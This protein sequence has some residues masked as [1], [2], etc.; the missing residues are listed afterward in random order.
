MAEIFVGG[1][2]GPIFGQVAG[3][4][5]TIVFWFP[6]TLCSQYCDSRPDRYLVFNVTGRRAAVSV[7]ETQWLWRSEPWTDCCNYHT[8]DFGYRRQRH[9]W[10]RRNSTLLGVV[11]AIATNLGATS[12]DNKL[13]LAPWERALMF[14][15]F[16]IMAAIEISLLIEKPGARVFA[17]SVVAVGLVLHGI[18]VARKRMHPAVSTPEI[19]RAAAAEPRFELP[20]GTTYGSPML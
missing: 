13:N 3:W 19:E 4:I 18:S 15:T 17:G 20:E 12:T 2:F 1:Q 11:G 9:R 5:V 6:V 10:S 7:R 8:R 14:C 16:L